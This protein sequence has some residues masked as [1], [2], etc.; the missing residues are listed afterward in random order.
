[1]AIWR[2]NTQ[3]DRQRVLPGCDQQVLFVYIHADINM[4]NNSA[5]FSGGF[6][7]AYETTQD[8][9]IRDDS[10]HHKQPASC[11]AHEDKDRTHWCCP[12]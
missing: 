1:M 11:I 6:Y 5:N 9:P 8:W 12:V 4:F 7:K 2:A 3:P 10:K